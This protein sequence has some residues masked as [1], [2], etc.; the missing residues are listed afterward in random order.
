MMNVDVPA[1]FLASVQDYHEFSAIKEMLCKY[2][3]LAYE[4]EEVGCDGLYHAVFFAG[5][6][7]DE[8]IQSKRVIVE[9]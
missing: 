5:E 3:G 6:R 2:V 8:F 9:D 4:Y 1:Y 7:P